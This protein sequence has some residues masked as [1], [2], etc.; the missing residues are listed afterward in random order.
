[1]TRRIWLLVAAFAALLTVMGIAPVASAQ[2]IF[3]VTI[4]FAFT[5]SHHLF[6]AGSYMVV[7]QVGKWDSYLVL[8]N[9]SNGKEGGLLM[10]RTTSAYPTGAHNSLIFYN[11]GHK[12]WLTEVRFE[13]LNLTSRLAEQPKREPVLAQNSA[14]PTVEIAME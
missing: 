9:R 12:Y 13:S 8:T 4:P 11:S 5:A 2:N 14:N 10:V 6:P 1:M 7:R 3:R